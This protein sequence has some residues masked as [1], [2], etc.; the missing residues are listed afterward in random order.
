MSPSIV[1][2]APAPLPSLPGLVWTVTPPKAPPTA[3]R[4]ELVLQF[5]HRR[6]VFVV[7]FSS[8]G[9]TVA[10]GGWDG[11][12]KLWDAETGDLRATLPD[13]TGV[14]MRL[15]F[16]SD[17]KWLVSGGDEMVMFRSIRYFRVSSDGMC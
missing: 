11:N 15:A 14:V 7:A 3:D 8:D 17:G 5:G 12:V 9:K 4:P 6:G 2:T 13:H 10:S 16:S 1:A